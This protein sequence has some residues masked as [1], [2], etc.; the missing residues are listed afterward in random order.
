MAIQMLFG[1]KTLTNFGTDALGYLN[2]DATLSERH[3][4]S[5]EVTAY[6]I[7]NGATIT[8]N[9]RINQTALTIDGF[10]TNAP[11]QWLG[12][13]G[14]A[15]LITGGTGVNSINRAISPGNGFFPNRVT[16][17]FDMLMKLFNNRESITVVTKL[18]RYKDM[19]ITRLS[20]PRSPDIGDTLHFSMD[21]IQIK[22][23]KLLEVEKT[24]SP[25]KS[26]VVKKAAPKRNIQKQPVKDI[27]TDAKKNQSWALQILRN[28]G[29]RTN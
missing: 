2:L 8:D 4:Y 19:V 14:N 24:Q 17:A 16:V 1:K 22:K 15:G 21:L 10:V 6:P 13:I 23:V 27:S 5:A 25:V 9:I 29:I 20:F 18:K 12:G 11:V 7:E 28:M 3:E 26:D